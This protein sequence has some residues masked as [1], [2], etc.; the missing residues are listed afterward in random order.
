MANSNKIKILAELNAYLRILT[1]YNKDNFNHRHWRCLL[2][3]VF[4]AICSTMIIL[5]VPVFISLGIWY[6]LE[7]NVDLKRFI[8]ALPLLL[9]L[10]QIEVTFVAMLT[11]N[12]VINETIEQLQRIIDQR[13]NVHPHFTPFILVSMDIISMDFEPIV[14]G[15]TE[16]TQS[17]EIYMNVEG[18]HAVFTTFLLKISAGIIPI[19]YLT[20][21]MFPISYAIFGYPP[22]DLWRL[23]LETQ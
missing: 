4:Y 23:P 22:P 15:C 18:K 13:N 11:K 12:R 16:S 2:H 10:L 14:I 7:N 1:A 20:S 9:S 3:S 6:L 8:V 17:W 19:L 21:A 5:L